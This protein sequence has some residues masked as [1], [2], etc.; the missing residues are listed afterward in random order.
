M[1]SFL[2]QEIN[3]QSTLSRVGIKDLDFH[4]HPNQS[5]EKLKFIHSLQLPFYLTSHVPLPVDP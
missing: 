2:E 5:K 1:K 4:F 3:S